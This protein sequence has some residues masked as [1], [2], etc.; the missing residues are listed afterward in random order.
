[1][2]RAV[3]TFTRITPETQSLKL[4][5]GHDVIMS[6]D[7][8]DRVRFAATTFRE[9]PM[10]ECATCHVAA[11]RSVFDEEFERLIK[12]VAAMCWNMGQGNSFDEQIEG[13]EAAVLAEFRKGV[14]PWQAVEVLPEDDD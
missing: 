14:H 9:R 7:E 6:N 2:I 8:A 11:N 1:M 10:I 5:C 12:F 3:E 4:T 13:H